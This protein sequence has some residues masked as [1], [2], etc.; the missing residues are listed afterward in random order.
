MA[1]EVIAMMTLAQK[2]DFGILATY[3]PLEY[4]DLG[5]PSLC[6]PPI[7]LT[8]GPSGVASGLPGVTQFPAP[9]AVAATFNPSI[10]RTIGV[11]QAVETRIKGIA[12]VQGP[13]INQIGR[14]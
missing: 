1:N 3:P 8:D 13:E 9:I 10:A 12:V 2:A 5:G 6:I 11:E 14:A 4:S 7:T